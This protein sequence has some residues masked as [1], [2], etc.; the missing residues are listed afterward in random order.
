MKRIRNSKRSEHNSFSGRSSYRQKYCIIHI[1]N[2]NCKSE[3]HV[4]YKLP[5]HIF[6][7]LSLVSLFPPSFLILTARSRRE[8]TSAPYI[9]GQFSTLHSTPENFINNLSFTAQCDDY[10]SQ[11]L[12][13]YYVDMPFDLTHTENGFIIHINTL[14]ILCISNF[15]SRRLRELTSQHM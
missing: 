7:F 11:S 9:L 3:N 12:T 10:K 15:I 8:E 4:H 6:S 14:N 5:V 1:Y 2:P 13:L